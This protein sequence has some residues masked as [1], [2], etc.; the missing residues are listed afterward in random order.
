MAVRSLKEILGQNLRCK[1]VT[2]LLKKMGRKVPKSKINNTWGCIELIAKSSL[3][4]NLLWFGAET[5]PYCCSYGLG[6]DGLMEYLPFY[7]Y[8]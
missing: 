7:A 2:L 3:V 1:V 8:R 4:T 5:E 6:L